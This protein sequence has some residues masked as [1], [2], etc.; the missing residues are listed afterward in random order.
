MSGVEARG[1][2]VRIYFQYNGEKCRET[3]PGGNTQAIVAQAKR[4][5]PSA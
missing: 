2:S 3:V 1:K 5:A 4:L